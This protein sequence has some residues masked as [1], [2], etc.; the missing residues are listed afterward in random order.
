MQIT[1]IS[2]FAGVYQR[3]IAAI[4]TVL[5]LLVPAKPDNV[6]LTVLS[7]DK[8]AVTFEYKNETGKKIATERRFII[9]KQTENGFEQLEFSDSACFPEIYSEL[10]PGKSASYMVNISEYFSCPLESGVYR[11]VFF[12][13][14]S[15]ERSASAEFS[16]E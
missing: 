11:I 1:A 12:Y 9:E 6:K 10:L 2:F 13:S 16:V 15:G 3:I 14:C 4:L 8:N 7:A 5:F